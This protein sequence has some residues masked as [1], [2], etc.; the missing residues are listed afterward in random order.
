MFFSFLMQPKIFTKYYIMI[1]DYKK[2]IEFLSISLKII[3]LIESYAK[4]LFNISRG[5]KHCHL[6]NSN[7]EI[8]YYSLF[9]RSQ[10]KFYGKDCL[11]RSSVM[12]AR[13]FRLKGS[14]T[15]M[16]F[17]VI[18]QFIVTNYIVF[19]IFLQIYFQH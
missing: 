4:N 18:V 19:I 9:P 1:C 10:Q 15:M 12:I 3:D 17:P 11:C 14:H 8:Q 13:R 16:I 2:W 5:L 7:E 6:I